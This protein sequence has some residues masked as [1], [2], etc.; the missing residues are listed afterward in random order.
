MK[1]Q[2]LSNYFSKISKKRKTIAGGFKDPEIRKKA[3][4]TRQKNK[5]KDE[6]TITDKKAN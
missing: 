2:D 6:P 5:V 1:K 3:L 4:E